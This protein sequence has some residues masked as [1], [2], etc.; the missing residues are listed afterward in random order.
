MNNFEKYTA[1]PEMMEKLL[2]E[3]SAKTE[4]PWE[5]ALREGD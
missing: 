1:S 5:T 4:K 2:K 3:A